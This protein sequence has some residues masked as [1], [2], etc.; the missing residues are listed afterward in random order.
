MPITRGSNPAVTWHR[1]V[2][3]AAGQVGGKLDPGLRQGGAST[4]A[5][6]IEK[7]RHYPDGLTRGIDDK[8]R[9]MMAASSRTYLDG[10]LHARSP[11]THRFD[12]SEF[13][14]AELA[15]RAMARS[16]ASATDL[17]LWFGTDLSEASAVLS[18]APH[19]PAELSARP[20]STSRC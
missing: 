19:M 2:L 5:T 12:L 16:S 9:Q 18:G 6:Q 8:L 1:F 4:L 3:A 11:R 17:W 13:D 10:P 14:A 15:R 20:R 7:F